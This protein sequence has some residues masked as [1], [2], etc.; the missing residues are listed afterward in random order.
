MGGACSTHGGMTDTHRISLESDINV[1]VK[2]ILK[3]TLKK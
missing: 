1:D 3:G 2:I